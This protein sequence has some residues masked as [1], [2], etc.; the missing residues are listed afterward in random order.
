MAAA[1]M[2]WSASASAD[3]L[4][5]SS[6]HFV[7]YSDDALENVR[8]LTERLERFDRAVRAL[9]AAPEDN[10]GPSA[11]VTVFVV[12]DIDAIRKLAGRS[13]VAGFYD[14]RAGGSVA[15]VPREDGGG[16]LSSQE[17]LFHE[18]THHW[19]LTNWSDAVLPPWYVEGGA[20]LHATARFARDGSVTFG[21]P[22]QYRAWTVRETNL[23]PFEQLTRLDP[24][25]SGDVQRDALYSRG[26]LL[27]HYLTFDAE[28]RKQ[29]AAYIVAINAGKPAKE[30]SALLGSASNMDIKL[31]NY[32]RIA[33][34]PSMTFQKEDLPVGEVVVRALTSGEAAVMPAMLASKRGVTAKT[35]PQV[36]ALAR[37]LAAPFPNDAAAQ[38]VLAEAEYDACSVDESSG[39]ACF[40]R[41]EAAADRAIAADPQSV[42]ALDYKGMAQMAAARR[43]KVTD[44]A[45]W[46]AIRQWF[47]AANKADKE[48][49]EPLILYYSTFRAAG[50]KPTANAEAGLLYAYALSPYDPNVRLTAAGVY[51]GRDQP[52]DARMALAPVAYNLEEPTR[53]AFARKVMDILDK[54]GAA[55]AR[56][57]LDKAADGEVKNGD[58]EK[59]K[60]G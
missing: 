7:V 10:R 6:K 43:D 45:R 44:P 46:T 18:Y 48:A 52:A 32:A 27:T 25:T 2:F 34:W 22:P 57:E 55:A 35:A 19:M 11:R 40:G 59:M 38:N 42:H 3:W 9:H 39:A 13:D 26:W 29:L 49:P 56:A 36:V 5:G 37:K 24:Q 53:A 16:Q 4:Q 30:A 47:L 15:F 50:Q 12:K 17:V 41:A 28:R 8:A 33:R 20:E 54:N 23:L 51:M 1:A 58:A 21:A 31:T 14:A 60:S